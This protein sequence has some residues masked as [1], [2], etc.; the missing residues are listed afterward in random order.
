[1]ATY[2]SYTS[3]K[4]SELNLNDLIIFTINDK[5]LKYIV[6]DTFLLCISFDDPNETN[7]NDK[8]FELL[9]IRDKY[10]F[11]AGY[12]GYDCNLQ[13]KGMFPQCKP[14]DYKALKSVILALFKKIETIAIVSDNGHE[15]NNI[16]DEKG[17]KINPSEESS[18]R[19][20]LP[21]NL[22][23]LRKPSKKESTIVSLLEGTPSEHFGISP[24]KEI[25]INRPTLPVGFHI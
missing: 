11:C 14:H 15:G 22:Q 23:L 3:L 10:K 20:V 18:Y 5:E 24:E 1:M 12:Y 13:G 2:K 4:N 25:Q 6:Y 19:W 9:N 17:C 16:V 7:S 21:E 8:I